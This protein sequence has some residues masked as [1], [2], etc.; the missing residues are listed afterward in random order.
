MFVPDFDVT[1]AFYA[2]RVE[3]Q[4]PA[5]RRLTHIEISCE[6]GTIGPGQDGIVNPIIR[7]AAERRAEANFR[8]ARSLITCPSCGFR[9]RAA[10]ARVI[11]WA[12]LVGLLF[13]FF[14]IFAGL[15]L[16]IVV[17]RFHF[18][19]IFGCIGAAIV[20]GTWWHYRRSMADVRR[21]ITYPER[22]IATRVVG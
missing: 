16:A 3:F 14:G 21:W 22:E 19:W 17:D 18:V 1:H 20:L 13:G 12:A 10:H 15:A 7:E 9:S 5:C 8:R 2:A 6:G 11:V 4:C